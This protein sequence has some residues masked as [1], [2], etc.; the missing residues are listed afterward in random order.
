VALWGGVF[1]IV[2]QSI[3]VVLA[4]DGVRA[5]Y[6]DA[7]KRSLLRDM[8]ED[9]RRWASQRL[10]RAPAVQLASMSGH[11]SLHIAGSAFPIVRPPPLEPSASTDEQLAYL[12]DFV[13]ILADESVARGNQLHAEITSVRQRID[14]KTQELGRRI[15]DADSRIATVN[16]VSVGPDGRSL[17]SIAWGLV[18][19]LFGTLLWLPTLAW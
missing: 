7:V 1:A 9:I 11:A 15:D 3:G 5:A 2:L 14:K 4:V 17:R 10:H 6:L 16:A 13:K 18:L 19:N 12:S 8:A